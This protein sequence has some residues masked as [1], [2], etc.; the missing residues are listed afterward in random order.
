MTDLGADRQAIEV[1]KGRERFR[2]KAIVGYTDHKSHAPFNNMDWEIWGLNDLYMDLPEMPHTNERV[3][4]FQ[5]HQWREPRQHDAPD[6]VLDFSEGPVNPRDPN[7]VAWMKRAAENIPVYLMT[8]R[9]EAPSALMLPAQ[10]LIDFFGRPYFTNSITWMIGLAIMELVREYT[11]N[12]GRRVWHAIPDAEIGVF[13]VDMMM[14]GGEGSEYGWQRPSCEWLIGMGGRPPLTLQDAALGLGIKFTIPDE[15]DLCKS[16]WQY[17]QAQFTPF[18]RKLLAHGKEMERRMGGAQNQY[19]QAAAAIAE[20]RGAKNTVD[21]MTHNWVPGDDGMDG[22][23]APMP[24]A[25]KKQGLVVAGE[26]IEPGGES[27]FV[28]TTEDAETT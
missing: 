13:G 11:L 9:D 15:S 12:D 23:P 20:L 24:D 25:H 16:A 22:T 3:R 5:C 4:W 14:M 7:H 28:Q 8:P 1:P 17:G 21:W 18:R 19:N 2:K 27:A 6:N 26:R 10:A